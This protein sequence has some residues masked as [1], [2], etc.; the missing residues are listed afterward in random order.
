MMGLRDFFSRRQDS[1]PSLALPPPAETAINLDGWA[2][3]ITGLGAF[4]GAASF[5]TFVARVTKNYQEADAIYAFSGIM[6]RIITLE[7][8][9]CFANGFTI[10]GLEEQDA[11]ALSDHLDGLDVFS[12]MTQAAIFARQ[13]GGAIVYMVVD[14]GQDP[15]MPVNRNAIQRVSNLI[16]FD[17]TEVTVASYGDELGSQYYGEPLIYQVASMGKSFRVHASRVLH[18]DAFQISRRMRI[19]MMGNAGFSPSIIDRLWD[20]FSAYGSTNGYFRETIK[21]LTQGVLKLSKINDGST[22]GGK[23][24]IINRLKLLM[25]QMSTIG[26]VVLDKDGEDYATTS[27]NVTGFS[28]ASNIFVDWV[29]AESG[30]P[31]SMLMLQTAGGIADGNNSGDHRYWSKNCA[32]V[33]TSKYTPLAKIILQYILLSA[34]APIKDV[35]MPFTVQWPPI[36]VP[37]EAEEAAVYA[38]RATGRAA[39]IANGVISP[40]E[41]RR[42]R[43]VVSSYML[44]DEP[45]APPSPDDGED[46]GT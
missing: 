39:D 42:S 4:N 9:T 7:P 45:D 12:K 6:A 27:R 29:V 10:E 32:S 21:K 5:D 30:I 37:T 18:F 3:P 1:A 11:K 20:S 35:K 28:D 44:D 40:T 13:Y 14:D 34:N 19:S 33:Q 17:S 36:D 31:R 8:E 2:N 24:S 25:Q 15:S 26:D 23:A 16:V 43:D 41:A 22:T 38:Q 46:T